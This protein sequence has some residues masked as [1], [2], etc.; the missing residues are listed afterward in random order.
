MVAGLKWDGE[1]E[2][3]A[4]PELALD[5]DPAAVGLGDHLAEGQ[6]KAGRHR[7]ARRAALYLAELLEDPP[8][9]VARDPFAVVF[10]AEENRVLPGGVPAAVPC[11]NALAARGDADRAAA[12]RELDRV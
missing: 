7:P 5:P 8:E 3:A 10:H 9:G 4:L 11:V 1:G 12:G 2:G 6:A